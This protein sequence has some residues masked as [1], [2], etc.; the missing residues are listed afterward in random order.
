[1]TLSAF[2]LVAEAGIERVLNSLPAGLF[3]V[4]IVWLLLRFTGKHG[5]R[6]RFAMWFLV[7]VAIAG[8]P[9]V[10]GLSAAKTLTEAVHPRVVL[11]GGWALALFSAWALVAMLATTRVAVGLWKVRQLRNSSIAVP[12]SELPSD[13]PETFARLGITRRAAI[14]ISPDVLVPTAVGFFKPLVLVPHW[15]VKDLSREELKVVLLHELAH[16]ERWDDWTNLAQKLIRAV[17]FFHPAVWWI[18]KRL[19]L[20][21]EMACDDAVLDATQ[22]PRAYAECLVSIAERSLVRRSLTLAQ[23]VLGRAK[24]TTLRLAHILDG[25]RNGS[26]RIFQPALGIAMAIVVSCLAIVPSVPVVGFENPAPSASVASAEAVQFLPQAKVIPASVRSES[27][28]PVAYENL[29]TAVTA[30]RRSPRA[31]EPIPAKHKQT[32]PLAPRVVRAALEEPAPVAQFLV[33]MQSSEFDGGGLPVV[34]FAVWRVTVI[35]AAPIAAPG[36]AI[37]KVI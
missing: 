24:D 14:R 23:T 7:L 22:N 11:S 13:L 27:H 8:L 10:P 5:S 26:S 30:P 18:E 19:S 12:A 28:T 25:R 2:Q 6:T 1:M 36:A 31:A 15:A 9:V 16:L 37:S 21:R 17:F 29:R 34:R 32:K 33:V 35:S 3:M 20:E 4:L